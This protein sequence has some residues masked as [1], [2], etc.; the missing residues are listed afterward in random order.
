MRS[1]PASH[2]LWG[3]RYEGGPAASLDDLN[4]SLPIDQ[5][6]WREDIDG[7]RAW[8]QALARAGVLTREEAQKLDAGLLE[9]ARRL[10]GGVPLNATDEDI[11]TLVERILYE[12]IGE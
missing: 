11:H 8:V 4:R 5:R 6:L 12:E 9:V 10:A 2:R 1:S 7:S 3:G